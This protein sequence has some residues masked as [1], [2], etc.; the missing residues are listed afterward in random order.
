MPPNMIQNF[1]GAA[2]EVP[3]SRTDADIVAVGMSDDDDGRHAMVDA[4]PC[5]DV[6]R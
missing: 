6:G 3:V 5:S 4:R 1:S 2:H